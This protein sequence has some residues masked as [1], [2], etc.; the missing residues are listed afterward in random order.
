VEKDDPAVGP[1]TTDAQTYEAKVRREVFDTKS[2]DLLPIVSRHL[3][4]L[5]A[6]PAEYRGGEI[7][8]F[9]KSFWDFADGMERLRQGDD[10]PLA[11]ERFTS[12][13]HGF[14]E[15]GDKDRK[16]ST[17]AMALYTAGL[18]EIRKRNFVGG[19]ELMAGSEQY[20]S[21]SG[22]FGDKFRSF[23][24]HTKPEIFF[25]GAINAAAVGD[26]STAKA[27]FTKAAD[28]SESVAKN[29]YSSDDPPHFSFLGM[30]RFFVA[31]STFFQVSRDSPDFEFEYLLQQ[32]DISTD[33]KTA[34]E[35][36][37][38]GDLSNVNFRNMAFMADSIAEILYVERG[39]AACIEAC[40][41]ST[42][43]ADARGF[44]DLR[45]AAKRAQ[46][47][48][49]RVG[50]MAT[51]LIRHCERLPIRT[52]NL[53]RLTRPKVRLRGIL[54]TDRLRALHSAS[55]SHCLGQS[56]FWLRPRWNSLRLDHRRAR[57]DRRL[58]VRR[59]QIQEH[60]FLRKR[61]ISRDLTLPIVHGRE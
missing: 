3:D 43:K 28:E 17:H 38:K 12:A 36:L 1:P 11:V 44:S 61:Q 52:N 29:Y 19:L 35:Y 4:E 5:P 31:I 51:P 39:L 54:R 60:D 34:S 21:K 37:R 41:K 59:Y 50:E 45:G 27:L 18:V 49:A 13:E 20:L 24:D 6:E 47:N 23:I 7:E 40:L 26:S 9:L 15:L 57:V 14:E 55:G 16:H 56:I 10:L 42:F 53:E 33:A 2:E 30:S 46:S 25:I 8:R 58:R 32:D 48:A 22:S